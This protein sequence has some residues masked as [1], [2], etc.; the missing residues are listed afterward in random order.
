[1]LKIQISIATGLLQFVLD[2]VL[3][4]QWIPLFYNFTLNL[5]IKHSEVMEV[6]ARVHVPISV[7][8]ARISKRYDVIPSGTLYPNADEIAYLQRL[9]FYKVCLCLSVFF[10]ASFSFDFHYFWW[11]EMAQL[12]WLLFLLLNFI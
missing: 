4:S 3:H 7:A 10:S 9:V 5:Q 12:L 1:M 11:L 6:G 8:E 2:P